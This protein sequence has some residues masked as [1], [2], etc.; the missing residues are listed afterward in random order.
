MRGWRCSVA[1]LPSSPSVG[2][3][4]PIL[5]CLRSGESQTTEVGQLHRF[6]ALEEKLDK[7]F[8]AWYNLM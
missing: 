6:A 8:Y 3:D 5:T 2:Q 7:R 4:R 1:R